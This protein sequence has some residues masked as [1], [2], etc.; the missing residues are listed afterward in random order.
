MS[1]K[2]TKTFAK[3]NFIDPSSIPPLPV[4]VMSDLKDAFNYYDK[5]NTGTIS[6]QQFKNILHNF[7]FHRATRK[8]MEDELRRH[9]IDLAKKMVG[10]YSLCSISTS[11][12]YPIIL[13]ITYIRRH[14]HSTTLRTQ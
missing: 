7:G 13:L 1:S 5:N 3:T 4:D 2:P 8:E 14:S 6:L 12:F 10:I 11:G 9:D